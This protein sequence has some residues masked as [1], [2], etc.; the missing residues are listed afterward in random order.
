MTD[1][2][3]RLA[4][5][6]STTANATSIYTVPAAKRTFIKAITL[7]SSAATDTMI[8]MK[9]ADVFVIYNHKLK[10]YDTITV[11]FMDQIIESGDTIA[12]GATP[13]TVNYYISGREVDA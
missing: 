12:I 3:K 10:P 13:N 9:F 8:N 6:S 5:G 11:P 4:K 1:V 7:C 2:S